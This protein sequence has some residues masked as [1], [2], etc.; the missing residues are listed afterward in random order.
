MIAPNMATHAGLLHHRRRRRARACSQRALREAVG[1]SLNRI[2]VDGDTSTNDMAVVL[3]SGA[4]PARRDHGA[5]A[6]TTTPSAPRSRE[7]ARDARGHDRARRRGRDARRR[8]ARGGGAQLEPMPTASRAPSRSRRS[9]RPR[10]TAATRTG[11]ASWPR[12]A[13]RASTSTS[14]RV[15]LYLGDVWV[16][17]GGRARALRRGAAHAGRCAE[18]PVRI[19]VRLNA[20]RAVGLDLDLRPLARAT[21]TSTRT[22]GAEQR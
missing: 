18:D 3:A 17:E 14:S 2:T 19:R 16:A 9:S 10:S 12:S 21:S 8:G 22:T 20:G 5:R 11:D 7:A 1:A 4:L 13:A 6:A 15:D